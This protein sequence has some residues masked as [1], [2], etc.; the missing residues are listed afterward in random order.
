MPT[1]VDAA[2]LIRLGRLSAEELMVA[3]LDAI[4]RDNPDLNV[5]VFLDARMRWMRRGRSTR[6]C[7]TD[8]AT[9]SGRWPV[10]RSV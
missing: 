1:V 9:S 5:F 6:R 2:Q 7:A 8:D 4:E 10:C 3:C